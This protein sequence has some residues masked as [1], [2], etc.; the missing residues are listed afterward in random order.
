MDQKSAVDDVLDMIVMEDEAIT[1]GHSKKEEK[2]EEPSSSS[3]GNEESPIKDMF[4]ISSAF[5]K[6]FQSPEKESAKTCTDLVLFEG[7]KPALRRGYAQSNLDLG[8]DEHMRPVL[9]RQL[10]KSNFDLSTQDMQ[11]LALAL[12]TKT[13]PAETQPPTKEEHSPVAKCKAKSTAKGKKAKAVAKPTPKAKGK[14]KAHPKASPSHKTTFR[15]RKTSSAYHSA[16]HSALKAGFS[17][18]TAKAKGKEASSKAA[19]QID[20]GVL[21]ED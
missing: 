20:I 11:T 18:Q 15:H 7:G 4:G 2:T 19:H 12:D 9:R 13:G 1:H 10:A 6:K 8:R 17:P 14:A 16:K 5:F 3:K 21:Q